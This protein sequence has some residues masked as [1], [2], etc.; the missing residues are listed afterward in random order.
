MGESVRVSG[1]AADG[2][3]CA[4]VVVNKV[5]T[6]GDPAPSGLVASATTI[7]LGG[8]I[9]E[10][11]VWSATALGFYD[12]LLLSG[13]CGVPEATILAASDAGPGAGFA[14]NAD[15]IPVA[16]RAG[17][18]VLIVLVGLLGAWL[19]WLRRG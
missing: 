12:V 4:A 6:I 8:G 9:P 19:V 18:L 1:S 13:A 10:T 2:Q 5:W 17:W 15:P 3:Y 11:V 7:S 14:V 16:S